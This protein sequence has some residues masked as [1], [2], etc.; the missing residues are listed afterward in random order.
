[1]LNTLRVEDARLQLSLWQCQPDS[2][3]F[4]PVSLAAGVYQPQLN[5]LVYLRSKITNLSCES[6]LYLHTVTA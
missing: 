6:L 5:E 4:Q 2:D 3:D 1:M